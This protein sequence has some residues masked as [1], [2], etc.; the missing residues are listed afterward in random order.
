MDNLAYLNQISQSTRPTKPKAGSQSNLPV[1]ITKI[2]A[3]AILAFIALL[4]IGN[5]ISS[6]SG[7]AIDLSRQIYV[8][9]TN[10]QS[11]L[12]DYNKQL[13]SS[14]LRSI[15]SA[16]SGTLTNTTNQLSTYLKKDES[17]KSPLEP[18]ESTVA[19]E[20]ELSS[21]LNTSLNNAKLNG[22]LDRSYTNQIQLQVSLLITFI[23]QLEQR[24]KDTDLLD[25]IGQYQTNLY[26]IDQSLQDYSSPSD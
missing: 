24:T 12:K 19:E 15:G 23:S 26:V 4:V 14:K 9:S 5:M 18:K 2:A 20:A 16:L 21:N 22:I 7:K 17:A 8:R 1:L 10:L 3:G 6:A 11:T 25:I 13:K